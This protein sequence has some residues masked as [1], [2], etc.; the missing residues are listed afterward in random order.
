VLLVLL[1]RP[2]EDENIQVGGTEVESSQNVHEALERLG[3]VAQAE[4]HERELEKAEWSG[5]GGLLC[6]VVMDGN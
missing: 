4:G 6:I 3:G 2:G 5:D 1:K